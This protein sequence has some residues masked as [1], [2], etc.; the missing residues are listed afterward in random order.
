MESAS[1]APLIIE[2][3]DELAPLLPRPGAPALFNT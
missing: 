3:D 1:G 2:S